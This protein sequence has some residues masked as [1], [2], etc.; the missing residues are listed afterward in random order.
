MT[1]G[2]WI[3]PDW[4]A[5]HWVQAASTTRHG[6]VSEGPYA[7][8]NLG[9]HVGDDACRVDMNRAR[10]MAQLNI[11]A[12][13]QWL[14]QVHGTRIVEASTPGPHEADAVYTRSPGMVCAV[15]TADCLPV[16]LCAQDGSVVAAVHAGWKG[17]LAGIIQTTVCTM[18]TG[19]LMAWLG[20]AIGPSAFEVGPEVREAFVSQN[21]E[22]APAFRET[23]ENKWL[24]D[25]YQ[26]ARIA[27]GSSGVSDIF[28]G[29][30]CTY[31]QPADFFSYRRDRITGRM[32]SLIWIDPN[33]KP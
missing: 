15:M 32:A 18:A 13:P 16:L 12:P 28:G 23:G 24:T 20:P 29:H 3:T 14:T 10:L 26:L 27:L 30:W 9:L 11:A 7:G 6:G 17:L 19:N 2:H 33:S 21:S 31:R 22:C 25:I 8:L 4:P 5:A 1:A